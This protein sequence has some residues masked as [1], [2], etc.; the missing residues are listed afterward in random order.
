MSCGSSLTEFTR[1][2]AGSRGGQAGEDSNL[3][4]GDFLVFVVNVGYL[5]CAWHG[6]FRTHGARLRSNRRVANNG[7]LNIDS[8]ILFLGLR[9]QVAT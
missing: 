1:L 6:N 7:S 9:Q 5:W 4:P 2:S 3:H 8:S